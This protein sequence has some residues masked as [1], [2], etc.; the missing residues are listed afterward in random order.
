MRQ[1]LYRG[2]TKNGKWVY[3]A[4]Y[5]QRQYY[6]DEREVD[7][8]ITTDDVLSNDLGLDYE[9]VIPETVGE[10]TGLKDKNGNKVFEGDIL[11]FCKGATYPYQIE[12]DGMGWKLYRAD[13]KRIKEAFECN[14]IHYVNISEV[15]GN[16]HD[17]PELLNQGE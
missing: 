4:Y 6:G 9:E 11:V 8:I 14:E 13:G 3:G 10:Y 1:I 7:C 17:N 16:I 15:I 5:K 12:W 2:K